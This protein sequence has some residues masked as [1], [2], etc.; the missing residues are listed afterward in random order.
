M[1]GWLSSVSSY[2]SGSSAINSDAAPSQQVEDGSLSITK[3]VV[4]PIKS[5][6]GTSVESS[7]FDVRGFKF[8]RRWMVV[9]AGNHKMLTARTCGKV[10]S[11][12][13]SEEDSLA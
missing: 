6:K 7:E 2:L 1:P 3:L 8:D 11:L 10:G 5:C 13:N 9:E 4:Y 12:R